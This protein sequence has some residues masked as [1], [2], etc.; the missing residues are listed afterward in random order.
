MPDFLHSFYGIIYNIDNKK[1]EAMKTTLVILIGCLGLLVGCAQTN[2]CCGDSCPTNPAPSYP[3]CQCADIAC[4]GANP[5]LDKCL[6]C[7]VFGNIGDA[8]R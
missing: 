7:R 6:C 1:G 5:C 3:S 8:Y 2:T 4:S